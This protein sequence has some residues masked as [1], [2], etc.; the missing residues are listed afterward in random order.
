GIQTIEQANVVAKTY[1]KEFNFKFAIPI[2]YNNNI[3]DDYFNSEEINYYLS[4]IIQRKSNNAGSITLKRKI[5]YSI[6]EKN[7][8][9]HFTQGTIT[10]IIIRK[11]GHLVMAVKDNKFALV[12]VE[13]LA[14]YYCNN[15]MY[16]FHQWNIT[17]NLD[18]L[19]IFKN[20]KKERNLRECWLISCDI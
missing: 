9:V 8:P 2:Y 19:K 4:T 11:D 12:S 3:F 7:E 1:I 14:Q 17:I 15:K 10:N 16:L 6:N 20:K 13:E 5:Y 18:L